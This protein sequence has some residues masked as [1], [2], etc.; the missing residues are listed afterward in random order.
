[1]IFLKAFLKN[2]QPI[3]IAKVLKQLLEHRKILEYEEYGAMGLNPNDFLHEPETQ[4]HLK[5]YETLIRRLSEFKNSAQE[6]S[7]SPPQVPSKEFPGT[8]TTPNKISSQATVS[9]T[10]EKPD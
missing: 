7:A 5:N 4:I 1:M 3:L 6:F 8:T 9:N 2:A 10:S